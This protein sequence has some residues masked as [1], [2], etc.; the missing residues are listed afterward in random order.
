MLF[1][2]CAIWRCVFSRITTDISWTPLELC[3]WTCIPLADLPNEALDDA[4]VTWLEGG[5][6]L[7]WK[8]CCW[9]WGPVFCEE[10]VC[11][12][13]RSCWWNPIG[14]HLNVEISNLHVCVGVVVWWPNF[15]S[16]WWAK[17]NVERWN[18][19]CKSKYTYLHAEH[20][21]SHHYRPVY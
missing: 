2:S 13:K 19:L 17:G 1:S 20:S 10:R 3:P 7:G 15:P 5:W 21:L 12:V 11:L 14:L 4:D 6:F 8:D 16:V 18:V 9:F